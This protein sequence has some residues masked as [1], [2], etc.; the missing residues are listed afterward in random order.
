MDRDR[1]LCCRVLDR[2]SI[3]CDVNIRWMFR[4]I[5]LDGAHIRICVHVY[6]HIHI[7]NC[8]HLNMSL[9]LRL[10]PS[11]L[12]MNSEFREILPKMLD[13]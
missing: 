8:V 3:C 2:F 5:S 13:T 11:L 4:S 7:C 12:F 10:I 9:Q 6:V 1:G